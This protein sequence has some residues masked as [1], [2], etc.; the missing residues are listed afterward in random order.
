MIIPI[1]AKVTSANRVDTSKTK[2]VMSDEEG[3]MP[4]KGERSG[5]VVS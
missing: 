1:N 3:N 5:E 2:L 4:S